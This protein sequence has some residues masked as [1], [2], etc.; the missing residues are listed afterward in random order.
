MSDI[1]NKNV[2][3]V[4]FGALLLV[5]GAYLVAG[6]A[7]YG[8]VGL[9]LRGTVVDAG[10]PVECE[11]PPVRED[12]VECEVCEVCQE[13]VECEVCEDDTPTCPD[14][15][16]KWVVVCHVPSSGKAHTIKVGEKAVEAHLSR[17]DDD[18]LGPCCF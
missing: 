3:L 6:C 1:F 16:S 14:D 11:D 7:D 5:A 13:P 8:D 10:E 18:Y 17:H 9:N 12:P 4:L 2:L 15:N